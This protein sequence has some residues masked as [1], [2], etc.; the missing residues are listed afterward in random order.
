MPYTTNSKEITRAYFDSLLLEQRLVGAVT[1]DL[2]VTVFGQKFSTPIMTTALSHL[3]RFNPGFEKPMEAYAAGAR[4]ADTLHWIGMC[5]SEEFRRVMDCGAKTVR[6]VKPYA[7]RDKIISQLQEAEA[8][9]AFAVGMD[10]DHTFNGSGDPDLVLG[11]YMAVYTEQ[12]WADFKQA[13]KLPFIMKGVLSV[14][15]AVRCAQLGMDGIVV[16]HHGGH[17]PSA[18]PPLMVLPQIRAALGNAYPIIVDCGI[19]SGLD[20]YKAMAFG[21]TAVGVGIHLIPYTARGADAVAEEIQKMS[22][23]L[24]GLMAWTGVKDTASFDP[25]VIHARAF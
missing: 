9:G 8:S 24:R 16:S 12:D 3:K 1:P 15:D 11:E 13:T 20:A 17:M 21:A 23:Q 7:D 19:E 10:I 25:T 4:L 5:E 6:I 14:H 18:V 2:S 22:A